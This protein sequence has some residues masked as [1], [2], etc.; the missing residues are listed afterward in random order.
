V[1]GD[2]ELTEP[3]PDENGPGEAASGEPE[4]EPGGSALRTDAGE[5]QP[6]LPPGHPPLATLPVAAQAQQAEP[7][8]VMAEAEAEAEPANP[9]IRRVQVTVIRRWQQPGLCEK[10]GGASAAA[11][12]TMMAR[13]RRVSWEPDAILFLDPRLPWS[14]SYTLLD[15]LEAAEQEIAAQ[16]GLHPTRPNV[17]AYR[18]TQLLLAGACTNDNVVAYYDGALHVVATH[19]DLQQSVVHE[20]T[21]HALMTAGGL[22][23]PAWAQEGIAMN[24]ARE[25]WWQSPEWL[26]RIAARP[27]SLDIME[28]SVPYTM[29]S[30]EALA[31]YVQSAAMVWCA[32]LDDPDG[33]RGLVRKLS[34]GN[35][36][37]TL[38]YELP[39]LAEPS[40]LRACGREIQEAAPAP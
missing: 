30:E 18:D 6:A 33:L 13:F 14:T 22:V 34:R 21:H 4:G 7:A 16:L 19:A 38:E 27:Y 32:T 20:Y 28:R 10:K 29:T 11:R 15:P 40:A 8:E 9:T 2:G 26:E 35:A 23:A 17:F 24:V 39:P 12:R 36:G 3:G 1:N 25:T 5:A 37:G 31:F